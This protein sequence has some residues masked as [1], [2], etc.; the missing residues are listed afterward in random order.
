MGPQGKSDLRTSVMY[1]WK[2]S[3]GEGEA[4]VQGCGPW[5]QDTARSDKRNL[6]RCVRFHCF[7]RIAMDDDDVGECRQEMSVYQ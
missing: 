7:A 4:L 2:E 1:R 5:I 3:I 6:Y